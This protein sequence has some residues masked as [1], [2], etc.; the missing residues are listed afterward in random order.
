MRALFLRAQAE[1]QRVVALVLVAIVYFGIARLSLLLAFEGTNAS[2]VWPPSGFALAIL[3]VLRRGLWPGV[4]SGAFV[5][6]AVTFITNGAPLGWKVLLASTVIA[7]GNA[8]EA[9]L[10]E[11]VLDRIVS[12]K[13]SPLA[14]ALLFA[15]TTGAASAVAAAIGATTVLR[16]GFAPAAMASSIFVTWWV[17]DWVGMLLTTPLL[18]SILPLERE[19]IRTGKALP[20]LIA[21]GAAISIWLVARSSASLGSNELNRALLWLQAG[22]GAAAIIG[23]GFGAARSAE[24]PKPEALA[25]HVDEQTLSLAPAL[26]GLGVLAASLALWRSVLRDHEVALFEATHAASEGV[27]AAIESA[28]RSDARAVER[29]AARWVRRGA[30]D[31]GEWRDSARAFIADFHGFEAFAWVSS[32]NSV[33]WVE[34]RAS[35]T[36]IALTPAELS[37][38]RSAPGRAIASFRSRSADHEPVLIFAVALSGDSPGLIAGA[39]RLREVF[40]EATAHLSSDFEVRVTGP[41]EPAVGR[42]GAIGPGRAMAQSATVRGSPTGLRVEVRASPR[43]ARQLRSALPEVI[44]GGGSV[45]S[46]MVAA[47]LFLAQEVRSRERKARSD[48]EHLMKVNR[49][50]AEERKRAEAAAQAKAEFLANMSHE[51]RTPMSAVVG[52][53]ALLRDTALSETQREY[54]ND[55][56]LSSNLLRQLIDDILDLSKL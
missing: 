44:L 53:S 56:E 18:L 26:A 12:P 6:N 15:A 22:I 5:A 35:A 1:R 4:A 17:G 8:T 21:C 25:L 29:L 9:T 54:V 13:R 2:P 19:V 37:Q 46:A 11:A 45:F 39:V 38:A 32:E 34:S 36:S 16:G 30:L 3:L 33:G 48:G 10:A 23:L 41:F 47:L 20:A 50:L 43:K 14:R 24:Q 52:L 49:E 55:L 51:L 28:L 31:E 27:T 42:I 40:A 7:L